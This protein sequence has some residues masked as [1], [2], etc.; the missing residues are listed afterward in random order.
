M[1]L[2]P[3]FRLFCLA[4]RRLQSADEQREMRL[5]AAAVTRWDLIVCGARR[6]RVAPL[7]LARLKA[8][9]LPHL[10]AGVA[11]ELRRISMDG[12]R[13]SLVQVAEIGRLY[14]SLAA[15]GVRALALKGVALSAQL[16][17]EPTRRQARDIDLLVDPEQIF[18]AQA[19]LLRAGYA[20]QR[21]LRSA[22]QQAA[23]LRRIKEFEFVHSTTGRLVELHH[24]LTDNPDLLPLEFSSLWKDRDEVRLGDVVV[25]TMPRHWLPLYLCVHGADHGW[26]RLQWLTDFAAA[27]AQLQDVDAAVDTA[28][29]YGLRWPFLQALLL[30]HDWLGLPIEKRLTAAWRE[31]API[32]RRAW[33]LR[34]LYSSTDWY[35]E[36]LKGSWKRILRQSLW[37]RLYRFSL[38]PHWRY[39]IG[40]VQRDWFS[41]A[42]RAV[43]RLPEALSFLYPLVRPWGWLIRRRSLF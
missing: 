5:V 27:L 26:A 43:L 4:L 16:Y 18:L 21:N 23:Y 40:Q 38:K 11:A 39:W 12:A 10:P 34:R 37:E 3:E 17:G 41:P 20:R 32:R 9:D 30:A 35:E 13:Q 19:V 42:D 2:G 31:S 36:A 25:A 15:A 22:R 24:R 7:V 29:A 1:E 14:Q 6:H 33:L 8:C 28:A